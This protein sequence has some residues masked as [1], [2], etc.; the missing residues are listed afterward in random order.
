ME[1]RRIYR[2]AFIGLGV[3]TLPLMGM[4][5]LGLFNS[6]NPMQLMFLC[7]FDVTNESE[8]TLWI[9]PV[10]TIGREGYRHTLPQYLRE[11][12][13]FTS[14][15]V[16][17]YRLAAGKTKRITYDW[18]DINFS[19]IA[20]MNESGEYR[21]LVVDANPTECQYHPP[22]S[23][24]YVIESFEALSPIDDR[25]L[26]ATT[27]EKYDFRIL[28]FNLAGLV[29]IAMFV[30]AFILRGPAPGAARGAEYSSRMRVAVDRIVCSVIAAVLI[31]ATVYAASIWYRQG[32]DVLGACSAR[33]ASVAV[34][35]SKS[36]SYSGPLRHEHTTPDYVMLWF[37][38]PPDTVLHLTDEMVEDLEGTIT[39]TD[40]DASEV[41]RWDISAGRLVAT[42]G[43]QPMMLEFFAVPKE[44]DY[45]LTIDITSG[46]SVFA[47]YEQ[48]VYAEY[49]SPYFAMVPIAIAAFYTIACGIPAVILSV[50]AITGF[51][52]H[53]I[54]KPHAPPPA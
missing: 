41:R 6:I 33:P 37:S 31:T 52:R 2:W 12:P 4:T 30:V 49:G 48:T 45:T 21:Q 35:F 20:V 40:K 44:G 29:P 54:W 16:G 43:E 17:G 8:E 26:E 14:I 13:A 19:E 22:A 23:D 32:L 11:F 42:G 3:L 1:R 50:V 25:V 46:A 51:R 7:S 39:I 18:D 5:A 38:L 34:D 28:L 36:G 53:G 10:G 24:S 47:R 9:T 27:T 15:Q